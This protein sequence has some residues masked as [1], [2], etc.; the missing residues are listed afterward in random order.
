MRAIIPAFLLML[1][2]PTATAREIAL[3]FDDA[4]MAD[5]ALMTREARAA[6]L[7][8]ALDEADVEQVA[9]FA[10]ARDLPADAAAH[11]TRYASAGHL[12][13]NHSNTHRALH[14]ISTDEYLADV[15][16]AD[17]VLRAL[18]NFRPWFRFPFLSEG[19]TLEKRDAV[20]V[21]L[22]RLGYAQGYVTVDNYDW[23]LNALAN[24]AAKEGAAFDMG[25]LRDLYVET[26][27][28]AADFYDDV[29]LKWL[30]RSPRHVL[31]LHE[32]DLAA[33]FVADLVEALREDGW[34]VVSPAEAYEDPIADIEPDTTFL[35][36]G[37]VAALAHLAGAERKALVHEREDE[38]VLDKLFAERVL[39]QRRPSN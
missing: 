13:A 16:A 9:F 28:S 32:N 24:K 6:A 39:D 36:Q 14:K 35:S 21:G 25:A 10:I 15:A 26:L 31:L 27:V 23:Y 3:T 2:S 37:R 12:V 20:R 34:T 11:L 7:I 22:R 4:P 38:A 19:S 33:L 8:A 18:P 30:G 17:R 29:A 1:L 5:S